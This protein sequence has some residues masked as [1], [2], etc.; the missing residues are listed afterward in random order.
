VNMIHTT[1]SIL[2]IGHEYQDAVQA[3][4]RFVIYIDVVIGS[5]RPLVG[6]GSQL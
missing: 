4:G 6:E 2:K 1:H 5:P 3:R